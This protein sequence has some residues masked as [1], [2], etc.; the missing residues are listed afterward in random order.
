MR[1]LDYAPKKLRTVRL[2][3]VKDI[4]LE[5]N[6]RFQLKKIEMV[7][8]IEKYLFEDSNKK[9]GYI[10][11]KDLID[12]FDKEPFLIKDKDQALL[13]ARY[14]IEDNTEVKS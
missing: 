4:G 11:V 1:Q 12:R 10:T 3:D 9:S 2:A 6:Y 13:F 8:V 14:L 5:L 7:D